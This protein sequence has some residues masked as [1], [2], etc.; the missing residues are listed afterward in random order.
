MLK[1]LYI[2]FCLLFWSFI[3]SAMPLQAKPLKV[4]AGT[5]LIGDIVLDLAGG[6]AEV[7]T[8]IS[9]SSC[10]G[11]E[12]VKTTDFVFAAQADVILVH[13]FQRNMPQVAEML[14]AVKNGHLRFEALAVKGSWLIPE[15]QKRAVFDIAAALAR[16]DPENAGAIDERVQK[17]LARIDAID[18]EIQ[19]RL[20]P[21]QG[22]PV[23]VAAM[24]AEFV[25]WAGLDVLRA[26]PRVED[27][28]AR[29]IAGLVDDLRGRPLAGVVD[30]YQSGSDA[31]LP[32]A[33]E[34]KVAHVVL[35]NFP[36]SSED[37]PD[38]FS[39]LRHN[40]E[41]LLRLGA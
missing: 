28:H 41:Q 37:A 6:Q 36:G 24:Q 9:G 10:P 16:V 1:R 23:V 30:N 31:G 33:L 22:R 5:S 11:H 27:M 15:V 8:L 39:L 35:S 19:A 20:A 13:S 40:A 21:V 34:L 18:R 4:I 25:A 3:G 7:L 14:D 26:Y 32:L 38:Y 29:Q 17:R 2:L 12:D